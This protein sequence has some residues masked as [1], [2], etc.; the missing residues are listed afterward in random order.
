MRNSYSFFFKFALYKLKCI[1]NDESKM[2]TLK[3][4]TS[5][6]WYTKIYWLFS[7]RISTFGQFS[8]V[9][10]VIFVCALERRVYKRLWAPENQWEA[11][12]EWNQWC[13]NIWWILQDFFLT[14]QQETKAALTGKDRK[15]TSTKWL[16]WSSITNRIH[17]V[18][19]IYYICSKIELCFI[20]VGII[21][22]VNASSIL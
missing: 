14:V 13:W 17:F 10:S 19:Y 22:T 4:E 16:I 7:K 9:Y 11:Y 5:V 20:D 3:L 12:K 18:K 15:K 1:C 8:V 6:Q 21:F 2:F